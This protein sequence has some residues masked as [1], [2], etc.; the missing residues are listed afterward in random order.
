[1]PETEVHLCETG[2]GR[3]APTTRMCWDCVDTIMRALDRAWSVSSGLVAISRR[4]MAPQLL[5]THGTTRAAYGPTEPMN[6]T[7]MAI[8]QDLHAWGRLTAADWSQV[9]N[10][11]WWHHWVQTRAQMA[12]DMVEGE[13]EHA[14]DLAA[15]RHRVKQEGAYTPMLVG[16]ATNWLAKHGIHVD[17]KRVGMWAARQQ[18][19]P[20]GR[21]AEGKSLFAPATIV[22]KLHPTQAQIIE[23]ELRAIAV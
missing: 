12:V 1:M 13:R 11:R 17:K 20:D 16:T 22:A 18:I 9:D 4:E 7:A 10:P 21:T 2:C 19:K 14:P 3:P 23:E 15:T 5:R 8:L 6:L